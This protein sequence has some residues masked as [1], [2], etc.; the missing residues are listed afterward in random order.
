MVATTAASR[1][2]RNRKA[3]S[4]VFYGWAAQ[5]IFPSL[6][7]ALS[8]I[9]F[10][11]RQKTLSSAHGRRAAGAVPPLIH[12]GGRAAFPTGLAARGIQGQHHWL[13]V[14]RHQRNRLAAAMANA[15]MP[16]TPYTRPLT[17]PPRLPLF[18]QNLFGPTGPTLYSAVLRRDPIASRPQK[19]GQSA[20]EASGKSAL[21]ARN[22]K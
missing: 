14:L 17:T 18:P 9:P 8:R 19:L 21:R 12:I 20:D 22:K 3:C 15:D 4:K 1:T 13:A 10:P 5:R 7:D 6:T 11:C 2:C 16:T